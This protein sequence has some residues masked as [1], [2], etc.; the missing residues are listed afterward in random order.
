MTGFCKER[1]MYILSLTVIAMGIFMVILFGF[2]NLYPY[3]KVYNVKEPFRVLTPKVK[4]GDE[5][6]V[7][8][9][10]CKKDDTPVTITEKFVDGV[11]YNRESFVAKNPEGCRTIVVSSPIPNLPAGTYYR[12][13]IWEYE[14]NPI[15]KIYYE[16]D[17]ETFEIIE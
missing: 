17:S 11:V 10:Y 15:R 1:C 13:S 5:L 7:E 4:V 14:V 8:V 16:F 12:K 6:Q 2:W 9:S 3:E